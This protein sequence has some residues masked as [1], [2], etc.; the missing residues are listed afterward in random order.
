M[1]Y[2]WLYTIDGSKTAYYQH[3]KYLY[4][5]DT[6]QCEYYQS[7]EYIYRLTDTDHHRPALCVRDNTVYSTDGRAMYF[8]G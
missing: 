8:Y 5:A 1:A 7:G 6:S 4:S 3:G 2:R